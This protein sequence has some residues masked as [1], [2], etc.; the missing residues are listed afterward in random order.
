[1]ARGAGRWPRALP[2]EGPPWLA[3]LLRGCPA[4]A[5][6]WWGELALHWRGADDCKRQNTCARVVVPSLSGP[7]LHPP[8]LNPPPPAP[9]P[10][11][12]CLPPT[13]PPTSPPSPAAAGEGGCLGRLASL[14]LESLHLLAPVPAPLWRHLA[15]G[16]TSLTWRSV[17]HGVPQVELLLPGEG[18]QIHMQVRNPGSE[19]VAGAADAHGRTRRGR[20]R[21]ALRVKCAACPA[22]SRQQAC[23]RPGLLASAAPSP[24]R[25]CNTHAEVL[26]PPCLQ[27]L[28]VPA[29]LAHLRGLL[30][31]RLEYCGLDALPPALQVGCGGGL[32]LGGGEGGGVGVGWG[33]A[34]GAPLWRKAAMYPT[35]AP[36]MP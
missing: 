11:P 2:R 24:Q 23:Q 21:L 28:G 25:T 33:A 19:G 7:H 3:Q 1:M 34:V 16:L 12:P 8:P 31:L 18:P 4:A 9:Q 14:H 32:F 27:P 29:E 35:G 15:A 22:N 6:R 13:H 36:S 26:A 10:A 5:L 30:A 17:L 20:C